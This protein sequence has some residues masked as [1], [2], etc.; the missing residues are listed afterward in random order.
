VSATVFWYKPLDSPSEIGAGS[1]ARADAP[2]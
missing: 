2:S 1:G